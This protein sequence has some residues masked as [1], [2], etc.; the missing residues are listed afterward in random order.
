MASQFRNILVRQQRTSCSLQ[1]ILEKFMREVTNEN[2]DACA[3]MDS[4][5][6]LLG[7][8]RSHNSLPAVVDI[9]KIMGTE[10]IILDVR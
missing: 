7:C 10:Y 8:N 4:A 3:L 1:S 2:D 6:G 5:Y 9:R